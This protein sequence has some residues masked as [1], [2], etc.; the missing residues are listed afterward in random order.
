MIKIHI[1]LV[2]LVSNKYSVFFSYCKMNVFRIYI[3]KLKSHQFC[4][5]ESTINLYDA[6]S[7][8]QISI[9]ISKWSEVIGHKTG[10]GDSRAC[11][12]SYYC[13]L[14]LGQLRLALMQVK[15]MFNQF[16]LIQHTVG[17]WTW[18]N[19]RGRGVLVTVSTILTIIFNLNV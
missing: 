12:S 15:Y 9:S 1:D 8:P 17:G 13:S 4:F 6:V 3:P 5:F 16:V 10:D 14:V 19:Q 11:F 2:L 18:H 7:S